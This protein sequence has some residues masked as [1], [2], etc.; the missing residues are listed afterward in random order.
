MLH[1]HCPLLETGEVNG[2]RRLDLQVLWRN[3]DDKMI[4]SMK[5]KSQSVYGQQVKCGVVG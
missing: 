1:L 3:K 2:E 5:R 4:K